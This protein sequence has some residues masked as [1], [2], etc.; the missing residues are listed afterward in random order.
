[1]RE[2]LQSVAGITSVILDHMPSMSNY[3][4][5]ERANNEVI[6]I[7][8]KPYIRNIGGQNYVCR[9]VAYRNT[10]TRQVQILTERFEHIRD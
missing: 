2:A 3:R 7:W 4:E 6:F 1:M 8:I 5:P 10:R 9:S